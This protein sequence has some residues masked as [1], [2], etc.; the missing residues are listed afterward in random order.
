MSRFVSPAEISAVVSGNLGGRVCKATFARLM[1][2]FRTG[3]ASLDEL[4]ALMRAAGFL[5][6]AELVRQIA[7]AGLCKVA[8]IRFNSKDMAAH[9]LGLAMFMTDIGSAQTAAD[10]LRGLGPEVE[11][12]IDIHA[13]AQRLST[14]DQALFQQFRHIQ[15]WVKGQTDLSPLEDADLGLV[16]HFGLIAALESQP[17]DLSFA[18]SEIYCTAARL[19]TSAGLTVR[20]IPDF[21][22]P[23]LKARPHFIL[24]FHT[25]G[26]FEGFLHCKRADLPDYMVI[27][28]GGYSG[29]S[30]LSGRAVTDLTLPDPQ[31][32]VAFVGQHS[33]AVRAGNVS[34]Y[35]QP[36]LGVASD[37]LP[38]AFVFVA[39]QVPNDRTQIMARFGMEEMLRIVAERF[40]TSGV[41]VVVK[42]HP[43]A[44]STALTALLTILSDQGL[45]EVRHDSI[46]DLIP[47]SLAVITVNSGV[48]SEAMVYQ[49]PIY[50]FGA[51]DYDAVTHRITSPEQFTDLT[52]PIRPA[53]SE[54]TLVRFIAYYRQ[55]YLVDRS[56][57][58]RLERALQ[59]RLIDPIL[60][61]RKA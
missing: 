13:T 49:K 18:L 29:W 6:K 5:G 36:S 20:V 40:Y 51:A 55:Q 26:R 28:P 60:R 32:A 38:K 30:S 17:S 43:K 14:T 23:L 47:Q 52:T 8:E 9:R 11:K 7:A 53:V 41:G 50:T 3:A 31:T 25:A 45:I 33:Q 44:K 61:R 15:N 34:K 2:K 59:E 37:P 19:A 16:G 58:G 56:Q 1:P 46:H 39:L 27:D 42:P 21:I 48:G 4:A 12:A 22:F 54:D 24:S 35:Q 57:A 10:D